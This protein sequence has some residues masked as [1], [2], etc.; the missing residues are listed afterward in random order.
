MLLSDLSLIKTALICSIKDLGEFESN[1]TYLTNIFATFLYTHY[2]IFTLKTPYSKV[3][4]VVLM[5]FYG[6]NKEVNGSC[7]AAKRKKTV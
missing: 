2:L 6:T 7:G 4:N 5:F 1:L 3:K